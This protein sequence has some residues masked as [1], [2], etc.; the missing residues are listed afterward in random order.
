MKKE[1]VFIE[2]AHP[3]LVLRDSNFLVSGRR[4]ISHEA[5]KERYAFLGS[6]E[7][8]EKWY[9]YRQRSSAT[10]VAG[11]ITKQ[12]LDVSLSIDCLED[13][14][15]LPANPIVFV[16]GTSIREDRA[17]QGF[18]RRVYEIICQHYSMVS[19]VTHYR[20]AKALW[21]SLA[22][23]SNVNIYVYDYATEDWLRDTANK[24]IRYNGKN[25]PYDK[26]WGT[27][28]EHEDRVLMATSHTAK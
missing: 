8:P 24:P 17:Y 18:T 6:T 2:N 12:G 13:K 4:Y 26:I 20:G 28:Y 27:S 16:K 3:I 21:Q 1:F 10:F 5:L 14:K 11:P 15:A 9:I 19:D 22:R 25:I 7:E 23:S